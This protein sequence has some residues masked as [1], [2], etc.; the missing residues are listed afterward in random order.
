MLAFPAGLRAAET[1]DPIVFV[2]QLHSSAATFPDKL[3]VFADCVDR[4]RLFGK[5]EHQRY[6]IALPTGTRCTVFV[7]ERDWEALPLVV[8]DVA[9]SVALALLVYPRQV[10][11]PVLARE[12]LE[13]G[14]AD[15]ALRGEHARPNEPAALERLRI[16]DEARQQ[17]L[18]AIVAAHG[19]PTLSMV[20]WEAANAAWLIAQHA[21]LARL[22]PWLGLMQDA[23]T[24]HEIAPYNLATSIDRVLVYEGRKQVYGTQHRPSEEGLGEPYPSEDMDRL[25][26]RRVRAGLPRTQPHWK[27]L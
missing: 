8:E 24:R 26:Q 18:A 13:L 14:R 19:W 7:G 9:T 16:G 10:P 1:T 3:A 21:P 25:G 6:R 12:L 27:G 11:A 5:V 20:G 4:P 17:R 22:K 23:A 2:G 15:Q